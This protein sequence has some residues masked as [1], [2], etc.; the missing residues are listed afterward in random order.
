MYEDLNVRGSSVSREYINFGRTGELLYLMLCR[1]KSAEDLREPI[2]LLFDEDNY[3]NKLLKRLQPDEDDDL[4]RRGQSYLPY[5]KH[6]C[7]DF[8]GEDW[9][10]IFDLKLPG[11]DAYQF[12]GRTQC[13]PCDAVPA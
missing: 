7:F 11:F 8:L 12:F 9:R 3:L 6:H 5:I 13:L 2:K 1:S 4:H 10:N